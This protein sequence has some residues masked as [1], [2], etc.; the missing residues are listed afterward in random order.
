[1]TNILITGG[2]RGIGYELVK[3]FAADANNYVV[4]LSRNIEKLEQLKLECAQHYQSTIQLYQVDFNSPSLNQELQNILEKENKH[5]HTVINNAGVLVNKPF[6]ETTTTDWQTVFTTN[7]F[8]PATLIKE[9]ISCN[10]TNEQTH[11][12]N[13][14]SM[15]GFQGSVKFT[16]LS[17]YSASKAALANLTEV[18]AEEY[19]NT[20]I[21]INCLALGSVQTEMLQEAFPDFQA[22]VSAKQMA[23]YIYQFAITG[24]TLFNGKII[25]VSVTTP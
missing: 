12:V 9:V 8:A 21:K 4:V 13:I 3:Q 15:G 14:S 10:N 11:I 22:K 25:P 20:N 2:S 17:A 5:F 7:V 16:G 19:K 24:A 1:M 18:L 23:K 6:S